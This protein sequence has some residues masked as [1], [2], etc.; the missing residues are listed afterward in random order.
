MQ[1]C[2]NGT[3]F[4]FYIVK[5]S[6]IHPNQQELATCSSGDMIERKGMHT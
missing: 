5:T 1:K 3:Y 6:Y 4:L 2:V